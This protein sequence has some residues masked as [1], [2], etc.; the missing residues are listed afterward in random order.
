MILA[1]HSKFENL[2]NC[3]ITDLKKVEKKSK[4]KFVE[5]SS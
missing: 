3:F 4:V 1:V 5:E 2:G